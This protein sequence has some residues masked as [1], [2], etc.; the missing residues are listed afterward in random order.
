[1]CFASRT[2]SKQVAVTHDPAFALI[3]LL[4]DGPGVGRVPGGSC[5]VPF[6]A[7]GARFGDWHVGAH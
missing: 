1:M 3:F 2:V 4:G 7:V 5:F 6:G